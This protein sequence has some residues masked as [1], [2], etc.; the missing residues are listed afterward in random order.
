MSNASTPAPEI[1]LQEQVN[2]AF[3]KAAAYTN[4][5][6]TLLAQIKAC[7]SVCRFAF[8]IRRDDGS[9]RVIN[10]WRA[11]HSHHRL[12]TKGGVRFS[13]HVNEDEVTGLARS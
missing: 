5:D 4:H 2:Q 13:S 9:V 1:S 3:D 8:P 6:A 12:P 7:N 11:E 10:A